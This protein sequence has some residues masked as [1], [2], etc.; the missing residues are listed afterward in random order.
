[1]DGDGLEPLDIFA[2]IED[3][4]IEAMP[5]ADRQQL[6][7]LLDRREVLMKYETLR[8]EAARLRSETFRADGTINVVALARWMAVHDALAAMCGPGPTV[9]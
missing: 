5:E 9:R 8:S 4:D 6:V 3:L 7:A 1:M 2:A